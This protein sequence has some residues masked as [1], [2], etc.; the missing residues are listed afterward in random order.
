MS[1]TI[2]LNAEQDFQNAITHL[3]EEFAGL[4]IGRASAALVENIDVEAYGSV[5]PLKSLANISIPDPKTIQIQP[6]D[7]G[8]LQA[9]E[10][11]IQNSDINITPSNDGIVIRLSIPPLTEERRQELSRVVHRLAEE[12]RISVIQARQ[13][14]H[15]QIKEGH[16]NGEMTDDDKTSAE[17][18]LQEK[19]DEVN[20][21]I[22]DLAKSKESDVMKV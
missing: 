4:Q 2:I 15:D 22:E 10:K 12:A 3:K 8:Q 7:R 17:K 14:V 1:E 13:K 5:Q 21:T 18:K 20:K 6:W 11:A 16:K 9:I 19:V